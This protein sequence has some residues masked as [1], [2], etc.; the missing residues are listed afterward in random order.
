MTWRKILKSSSR[1]KQDYENSLR[2]KQDDAHKSFTKQPEVPKQIKANRDSFPLWFL[3]NCVK[4]AFELKNYTPPL[5]INHSQVERRTNAHDPDTWEMEAVVY[6]QILSIVNK[7]TSPPAK[8][9]H[10]IFSNKDR[11]FF[12]NDALYLR[13]PPNP[14]VLPTSSNSKAAAATTTLGME[15]GGLGLLQ[16]VV[17]MFA[18]DIEADLISFSLED[19]KDLCLFLSDSGGRSSLRNYLDVF[20]NKGNKKD[21]RFLSAFRAIHRTFRVTSRLS[22]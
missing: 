16:A 13:F 4:T 15:S 1:E 11:S 20:F 12:T 9:S 22:T 3:E 14:V 2:E 7:E 19:V 21:V 10:A 18:K 17:E 5:I 6:E 8:A